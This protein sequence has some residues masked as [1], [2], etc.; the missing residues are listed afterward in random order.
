ML[1]VQ[2][3]LSSVAVSFGGITVAKLIYVANTSLDG[4][5]E[6]RDG[7]FDWGTPDEEYFSFINDL[8]RSV[9]TYLYGR[10]LYE[11]MIYW[12]TAPIADQP[13]WVLDFTNI[14]RA[15]DKIVFSKTLASM[16]SGRTTLEREFNVEA[17]QRMK[18]G[19]GHDL[20]VGG[21]DLAAQAFEAGLVDECHLLFW[22]VVLGGGKHALPRHSRLNLQLLNQRRS[23]GGVVHLHYRIIQ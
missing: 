18:A 22:P 11:T 23:Q 10:R 16:S 9:G 6:D 21:A 2:C 15:A 1:R 5:T 14:W 20:T 4:Y 17:I 8:E 13:P 7:G 3:E 19:E 12:E